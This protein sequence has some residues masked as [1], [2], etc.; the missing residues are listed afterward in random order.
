MCW[1]LADS[2]F[3]KDGEILALE[4]GFIRRNKFHNLIKAVR[5]GRFAL[6]SISFSGRIVLFNQVNSFFDELGHSL[7][8]PAD[9]WFRRMNLI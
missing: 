7:D 9:V 1:G 3:E 2:I 8:Q 6:L 4:V 5:L